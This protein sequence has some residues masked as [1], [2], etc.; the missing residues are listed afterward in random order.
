MISEPLGCACGRRAMA[1]RALCATCWSCTPEG[2]AEVLA[3][4]ERAMASGP[5]PLRSEQL[6]A[7]GNTMLR[8]SMGRGR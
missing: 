7:L 8:E 3:A 1:G 5:A 4:I 2:H 6:V